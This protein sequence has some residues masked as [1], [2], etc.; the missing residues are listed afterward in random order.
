MIEATIPYLDSPDKLSAMRR[1]A[2]ATAEERFDSRKTSLVLD[3]I[4]QESVG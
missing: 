1:N 3:Q 4:Y 2:R